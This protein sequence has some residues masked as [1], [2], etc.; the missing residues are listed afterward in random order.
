ML[1]LHSV[2]PFEA[3]KNSCRHASLPTPKNPIRTPKK[4]PP[5]VSHL[6]PPISTSFLQWRT[7]NFE[8]GDLAGAGV[9][10]DPV[11]ELPA[12]GEGDTAAPVEGGGDA[13]GE[14]GA[15]GDP[16]GPLS[17]IG[18]MG[19]GNAKAGRSKRK[20]HKRK[21]YGFGHARTEWRSCPSVRMDGRTDLR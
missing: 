16:V 14:E 21:E 3:R 8:A 20:Q 2:S 11:A 19:L 7:P 18:G 17:A 10:I 5:K 1:I 13:G 4:N 12:E 15:L 9:A 6:L